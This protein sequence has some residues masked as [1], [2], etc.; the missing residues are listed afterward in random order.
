MPGCPRMLQQGLCPLRLCSP[1]A[2]W[3]GGP[4]ARK[5]PATP[6]HRSGGELRQKGGVRRPASWT[7]HHFIP[8]VLSSEAGAPPPSVHY[9]TALHPPCSLPG[10]GGTQRAQAPHP[11]AGFQGPSP[12]LLHKCLHAV[13]GRAQ[14]APCLPRTLSTVLPVLGLTCHLASSRSAP[15]HPPGPP[16]PAGA[17]RLPS[18][19]KALLAEAGCVRKGL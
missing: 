15:G 7:Q 18:I 14:G 9:G 12:S 1:P 4:S 10:V 19:P 17:W 2:P 13:W 16:H 11:A 8:H 6:V 3:P 5:V